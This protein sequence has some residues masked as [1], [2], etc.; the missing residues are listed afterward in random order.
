MP[1]SAMTETQQL[2]SARPA[3]GRTRPAAI[4]GRDTTASERRQ[5]AFTPEDELRH[6]RH[7][8]S[9][10]SVGTPD[11]FGQWDAY[12][13]GARR[14]GALSL[15]SR[16]TSRHR[17]YGFPLGGGPKGWAKNRLNVLRNWSGFWGIDE[18][19]VF[20]TASG[21]MAAAA[22]SMCCSMLAMTASCKG[23]T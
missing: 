1:G 12:A 21:D 5:A 19:H 7:G 16:S 17:I 14:L 4:A 11:G 2:C 8:C 9:S 10:G 13:V 15:H 23:L 3:A 18:N 6:H 22:S 20:I